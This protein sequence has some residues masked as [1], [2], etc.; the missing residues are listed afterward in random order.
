MFCS[1][2]FLL[3]NIAETCPL[4]LELHLSV[5]SN[6]TQFDSFL[7]VSLEAEQ[8]PHKAGHDSRRVGSPESDGHRIFVADMGC[9]CCYL[10]PNQDLRQLRCLQIPFPMVLPT[11]PAKPLGWPGNK[12]RGTSPKFDQGPDPSSHRSHFSDLQ[13]LPEPTEILQSAF[14][15]SLAKSITSRGW[16]PG[17][18]GQQR[19]LWKRGHRLLAL[20]WR[21]VF[22]FFFFFSL[23]SCSVILFYFLA[24]QAAGRITWLPGKPLGKC[25]GLLPTASRH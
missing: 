14:C 22:I 12:H 7:Q 13:H 17:R 25:T 16:E 11:L 24:L 8:R 9:C 21:A 19:G 6:Q 20:F 3:Q 5:E 23:R 2:F 10:F 15:S 18:R 1:I 4:E